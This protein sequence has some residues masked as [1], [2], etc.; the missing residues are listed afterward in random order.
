MVFLPGCHCG[1]NTNSSPAP[2]ALSVLIATLLIV[3]TYPVFSQTYDEPA[4]L[5]AGMEWLDRG[6]YSY[7]AIHPPLARIAV[8][9]GPYLAGTRIQGNASIWDEGNALLEYQGQ[10]Q[11]TL[12]LPGLLLTPH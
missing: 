3:A 1:K 9:L 2:A 11:R 5:A 4:H 12:K 10:H 8:A 7:E 6:S